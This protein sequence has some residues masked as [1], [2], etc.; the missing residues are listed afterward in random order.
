MAKSNKVFRE[1]KD[2]N[3]QNMMIF[4]NKNI[5]NERQ[6]CDF[7]GNLISEAQNI[8]ISQNTA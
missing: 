5:E 7:N 6:Q 1:M 8:K 4:K 3:L 2:Q